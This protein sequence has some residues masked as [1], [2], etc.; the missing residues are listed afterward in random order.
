M[1]DQNP[2]D[3]AISQAPPPNPIDIAIFNAGPMRPSNGQ[4]APAN[5]IDAAIGAQSQLQGSRATDALS[6]AT[7]IGPRQSTAL[8]RVRAIF[9]AK[10]PQGSVMANVTQQTGTQGMPQLIAPEVAMT[11]TEQSQHPYATG[12]LKT[13]GGITTPPNLLMLAGTGGLRSLPGAAGTIVPR[14]VSAGFAASIVKGIYDRVPDVQR[15]VAAYNAAAARND[16][17]TMATEESAIKQTVAEL[18]TSGVFAA[19]AAGHVALGG[20]AAVKPE[21]A[22]A[23]PPQ[24]VPPELA[25][26]IRALQQA[27]AAPAAIPQGLGGTQQAGTPAAPV[28]DAAAATSLARAAGMPAEVTARIQQNAEALKPIVDPEKVTSRGDVQ[29]QLDQAAST[30]QSN[31]DPRMQEPLKFPEQQRL[32][33][34]LGMTPE[35]L[36]STPSGRAF[37]AEQV[38]AANSMLEAS[39]TNVMN[40]ARLAATGDEA[41][42]QQ[43]LTALARHQEIQDVVTGR[44]AAEAGRA[45]G[46]FRNAPTEGTISAAVDAL[47]KL[48]PDAQLTAA[49]QLA[50]IDPSDAGAMAK[51]TREI[52]P[53][54]TADKIY[55]AW[56]NGL[57]S[58]GTGIVKATSDMTM[59]GLGVVSRP[60]SAAFDAVHSALTGEPRTRYLGDA[61]ADLYG[62]L[63]GMPKALSQFSDTFFHEKGMGDQ[64]MDTGARTTAIKGPLGYVVR[65]PTRFLEAVTDAAKL[66]NYSADVHAQ[67]YRM[68]RGEGLAGEAAW[69]RAEEFASNPTPKMRAG[70]GQYAQEQTFQQKLGPIGQA[71]TRL[72]DAVPG[73]KFLLPFVKTPANI[74]R[75]AGEFSPVGLATTAIKAAGGKLEPGALADSLAKNSLG[76]AL[77]ATVIYHAMQ[78]NIT[79]SGPANPN[80]RKRL[81]AAGWQPYSLK[82]GNHYVSYRKIE[83][84]GTVMSVAVDVADG[85]KK[86][87]AGPGTGG[88]AT[89]LLN[90]IKT[91]MEQAE[92]IGSVMRLNQMFEGPGRYARGLLGTVIP[93]GVANVARIEDTTVRS[94]DANASFSEQAKQQLESR[95]PG[96][97]HNLPAVTTPEGKPLQRPVSAFG[98][99]NP[100]PVSTGQPGLT[101]LEASLARKEAK[102]GAKQARQQLI[103]Q[104]EVPRRAT[105]P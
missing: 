105:K 7:S 67:A 78:G 66:V 47:S 9:G 16:K 40:M 54:S 61:Q 103:K 50:K 81:E 49:Q 29:S 33:Q 102:Q 41:Y 27:Q 93:T 74:L 88:L 79:G 13:V 69:A 82:V 24:G 77:A 95:I 65:T 70:A 80:D 10:A 52:M 2:I 56:L 64:A 4:A 60:V 62:M 28:T 32:A 94:P 39:R 15:Q 20:E 38:V 84:L 92:F 5:P 87:T 73:G 30:L 14:L 76:T 26:K 19:L 25:E 101:A 46:A 53:S 104:R 58:G 18:A 96:L 23:V 1:P 44:V 12:A 71:V 90:R 72:R 100:Y 45:L 85:I 59:R 89:S 55:E 8:D 36:L 34:N 91:N 51:F 48:P 6:Q 37:S 42:S 35:Q 68:A 17:D 63:R 11:P 98:G 86:G 21:A 22:E 83:P 43:F 57:L 99:F 31:P 3:A 75:A 97:T